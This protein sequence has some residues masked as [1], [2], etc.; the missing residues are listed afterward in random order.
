[1]AGNFTGIELILEKNFEWDPLTASSVW[2]F[3]P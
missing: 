2:S 1:M 3:G